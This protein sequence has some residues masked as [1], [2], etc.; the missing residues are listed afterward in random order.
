MLYEEYL[1]NL[2]IGN[3]SKNTIRTYERDLKKFCKFFSLNT[4]EQL[5]LLLIKDY[6]DFFES[7]KNLKVSSRNGIIRCLNA[8]ITWCLTSEKITNNCFL[9]IK[10]GKSKFIKNTRTKKDFL[11]DEEASL[12]ISCGKNLRERFMIALL[13]HTGI[14]RD[15]ACKIKVS[16]ISG[17]IIKITNKGGDENFVA[18]NNALYTLYTEYLSKRKTNSEYLFYK[19]KSINPLS[20][21][22][23]NNIVIKAL[24]KSGIEKHITAH[25][26][27]RGVITRIYKDYDPIT[28]QKV[29]HH[30]SSSTT[31][32]YDESGDSIA[33]N[34]LSQDSN[35]DFNMGAH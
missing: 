29:A 30:K 15:V 2:E 16:N 4:Y 11:T 7:A 21:T 1:K 12:L 6:I 20:G 18:M 31:K 23:I 22:T 3:K 19:G 17:N 35:I 27:R 8:Y 14:R 34:I 32:I 25:S 13:A 26:L 10:F 9:K 5:N 24:K 33:I 28:A